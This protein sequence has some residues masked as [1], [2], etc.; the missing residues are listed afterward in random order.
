MEWF[1]SLYLVV[2]ELYMENSYI[3]IVLIQ[4]YKKKTTCKSWVLKGGSQI[5]KSTLFLMNL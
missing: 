5:L 1:Y 4:K 3:F 2:N